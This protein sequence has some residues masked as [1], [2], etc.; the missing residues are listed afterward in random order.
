MGR[1]PKENPLN[2]SFELQ[3]I[4]R[5]MRVDNNHYQEAMRIRLIKARSK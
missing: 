4:L 3:V 5:V 2:W 1:F